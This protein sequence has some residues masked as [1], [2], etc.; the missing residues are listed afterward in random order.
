MAVG[1]AR[2]F[3]NKSAAQVSPLTRR[4]VGYLVK[5]AYFYLI[6]MES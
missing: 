4:R 6:Y 5:H 2:H 1:G 3:G